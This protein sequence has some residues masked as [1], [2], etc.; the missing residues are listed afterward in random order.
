MVKYI[1]Y[2]LVALLII[3]HV[4]THYGPKIIN[5][6]AS[7]LSGKEVKVV[8]EN[9]EKKSVLDNAIEKFQENVLRR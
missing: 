9:S 2:L 1:I 4:W 8:E 5:A 6:V 7:N 3:D